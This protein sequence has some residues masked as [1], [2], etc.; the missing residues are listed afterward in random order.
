M[1]ARQ[2]GPYDSV[3]RKWLALVER[4][5]QFFI[6]L[7]DS[8]RWKHYY[9][10]EDELHEEV[11]KVIVLRTKW[12]KIVEALPSEDTPPNDQDHNSLIG[13]RLAARA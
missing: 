11:R 13:I 6:D 5:K 9:G 10:T 2:V 7:C 8:G 3:S 1:S 12:L 4:R